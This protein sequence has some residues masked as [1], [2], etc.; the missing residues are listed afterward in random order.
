MRDDKPNKIVDLTFK[1]TL[2]IISYSELLVE[3]GKR[4]V[5][6]QL[7]KSGTSIGVDNFN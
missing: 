1:V 2:N 4:M 6:N 5:A 3:S 7:L